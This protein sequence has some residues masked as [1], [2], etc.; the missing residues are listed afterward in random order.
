MIPGFYHLLTKI[1][2][3][4]WKEQILRRDCHQLKNRKKPMGKIDVRFLITECTNK[5]GPTPKGIDPFLFLKP[6]LDYRFVG[7]ITASNT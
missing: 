7:M 2:Q 3:T 1:K 4:F 5:K 6:K